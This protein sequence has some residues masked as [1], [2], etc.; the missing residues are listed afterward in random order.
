MLRNQLDMHIKKMI[1]LKNTSHEWNF[2]NFNNSLFITNNFLISPPKPI[3]QVYK[4][5]DQE[6]KAIKGQRHTQRCVKEPLVYI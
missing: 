3:N 4:L 1:Y 2:A 6:Y 5:L